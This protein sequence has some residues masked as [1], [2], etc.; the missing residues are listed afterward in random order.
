MHVQKGVQR[1]RQGVWGLNLLLSELYV[2][3]H[4]VHPS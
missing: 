2:L 1:D 4:G 3:R